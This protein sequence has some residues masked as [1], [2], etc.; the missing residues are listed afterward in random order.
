MPT[1]T[2]TRRIYQKVEGRVVYTFDN[3]AL[4]PWSTMST[5][6]DLVTD[7]VS[8]EI[9]VPRWRENIRARNSATNKL[10]GVK[11]IVHGNRYE[12]ARAI[13]HDSGN[14]SHVMAEIRGYLAQ[15]TAPGEGLIAACLKDAENQAARRYYDSIR[16]AQRSIQGLVTLGEIGESLRMI[17][18]PAESLF[19]GIGSYL[20]TVKKRASGR[21]IPIKR[22]RQI[23]GD[24]WLEYSFGWLPLIGDI[25]AGAEGLAKE[26]VRLMEVTSIKG[27]GSSQ[28]KTYYGNF[29][30]FQQLFMRVKR[31]KIVNVSRADVRY[32]GV[33]GN[34]PADWDRRLARFG[35]TPSD[36]LPAVWELIPYSF[37]VDYFTNIGSLIS[38]F[39]TD[40]SGLK[41]AERGTRTSSWNYLEDVH[42][43]FDAI[44]SQQR[45]EVLSDPTGGRN[46]YEI[47]R[48]T[49]DAA[50]SVNIPS[51][52]FRIPGMSLKWLN[53][54]ALGLSHRSTINSLR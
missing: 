8:Y 29:G 2:F 52:E 37:L 54:A 31:N 32:H 24:T 3:P 16:S 42:L 13:L 46:G 6:N 1:K 21:A 39:S 30:S 36:F 45:Y 40:V 27:Y 41:W 14:G 49:R 51:L 47:V 12:T 9:Y 25:K 10:T 23:A 50:G 53:L 15:M 26:S 43:E 4:V 38:A 7:S 19:R 5:V 20:G 28:N 35:F 17:R 18:H 33:V 44:N 22:K 34:N 48:V 11:H